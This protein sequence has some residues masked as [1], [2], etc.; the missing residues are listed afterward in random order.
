MQ[1]RPSPGGGTVVPGPLRIA[2]TLAPDMKSLIPLCLMVVAGSAG[3]AV[4]QTA[5]A[6]PAAGSSNCIALSSDHQVV[7][8]NADQTVLL[9]NGSDHYVVR[10]AG[11]CASAARSRKLEFDTPAQQG[12]LC[13]AG[14]SRLR[15]D[16]QSCEV[17]SLEPISAEVFARRS[18]P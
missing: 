5:P 1:I 12:Q 16:S 10:F 6:T 3:T 2:T 4:A 18:R 8:K 14:G 17:A 15:T 11:S 9:Q 7:R 13:G